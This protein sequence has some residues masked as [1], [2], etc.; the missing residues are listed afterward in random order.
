MLVRLGRL[1][2]SPEELAKPIPSLTKRQFIISSKK[3]S[4]AE[5]RLERELFWYREA[6]LERI[7]ASWSEVSLFA[8][9]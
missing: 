8:E 4:V 9:I 1:Y 6:L 7:R 3:R 2:L 5:D